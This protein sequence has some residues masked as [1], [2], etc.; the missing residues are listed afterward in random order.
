ML[1]SKPWGLGLCSGFFLVAWGL[2]ASKLCPYCPSGF[3]FNLILSTPNSQG[4]G[5]PGLLSSELVRAVGAES[6]TV[7][8]W[9]GQ[10]RAEGTHEMILDSVTLFL[11]INFFIC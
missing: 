6:R 4:L 10:V 11:N 9:G 3:S 2:W 1:A 7:G 5:L 8:G